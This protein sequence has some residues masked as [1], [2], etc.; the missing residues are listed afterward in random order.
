M[1]IHEIYVT[2]ARYNRWMNEKLMDACEALADE[3]RKRDRGA[4]FGSIHGLWN[5]IL[6]ADNI[7]MAR[8]E[9]STFPVTSLKQQLF[10]DW[11]ELRDARRKMD[12]RIEEFV[13][14]LPA[15]N[16]TSTLHYTSI[17]NPAPQALP[18]A[19]TLSHL[20]NHATHHRGQI[21]AL[22]EQ[23][24]LDCGVTDLVAMPRAQ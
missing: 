23:A 10:S 14:T 22:M 7:W 1:Q 8:F 19:L 5:H 20:F 16:L 15:E 18:F 17:V 11:K 12:D 3:E 13:A 6:L 9:G 21:T 4:P 2:F 24:G